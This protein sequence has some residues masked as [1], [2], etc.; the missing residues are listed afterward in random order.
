[1]K[2][3]P[4]AAGALVLAAAPLAQAAD[5][6][7]APPVTAEPVY[8]SEPEPLPAAG[9]WYLRGDIGYAFVE[10][11]G[12]DY[13][14]YGHPG[15]RGHFSE[16]ELKD[17]LTIGGGIGYQI[18]DYFRTDVTADYL[19]ETDFEGS[20][21]GS[22]GVA[23]DCFSTDHSSLTAFSLLANA[24]VDLGTYKRITPYVGA[25]IGGTYVKWDDLE[26]TSCS[27]LNPELCDPT[28]KHEG[29]GSWR[30]T[31]AL[32]AGASVDLRCDVKLD[33]GYRYRRV[34][35]GK[36][37]GYAVGGGPGF[38]E[39]F[40]IHEVRAGLRYAFGGCAEPEVYIPEV[41]SFP[42]YK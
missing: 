28:V 29:E 31:Y 33:A 14:L 7:E 5:I 16:L 23:A 18:T 20:T 25:G 19:F 15:A 24:Y 12:I 27:T 11:D 9:G 42:V 41:P 13:I 17:G 1:M 34:E 37:F 32:M 38:D 40:D 35:D 36:M 30:F 39:G 4:L 21:R 6:Y 10:T 3:L 26:N 8:V 2:T 22:C